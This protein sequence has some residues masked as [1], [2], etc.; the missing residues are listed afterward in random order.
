LI[1]Y[2]AH[3]FL[4]LTATPAHGQ[5]ETA[6]IETMKALH[7]DFSGFTRSYWNFYFGYGLLAILWG[8]IEMI[9]IWQLSVLAKISAIQIRPMIVSL[10]LANLG[11]AILILRYFFLIPALFDLIVALVLGL[12]FVKTI[13]KNPQNR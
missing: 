8:V 10:F 4:F 3:S 11:H 9:L 7:W 6:L 1:Q 2:A 13:N 12:A 5:E